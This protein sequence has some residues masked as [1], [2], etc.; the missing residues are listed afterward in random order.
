VTPV[1]NLFIAGDWTNTGYPATIEGAI[2]SGERC[3]GRAMALFEGG[4]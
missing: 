2:M 3:A 4:K 1:H